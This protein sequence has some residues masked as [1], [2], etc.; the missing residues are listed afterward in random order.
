MRVRKLD[1][2]G[3][4]QFGFGQ[5][6]FWK[7]VPDAPA[8]CVMTRLQLKTGE[9]FLD[10]REGTPWDTEVLGKYTGST[11]DPVIRSRALGTQGVTGILGYVSLLSRDRRAFAVA[12]QVD[13][14]YGQK[15]VAGPI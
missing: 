15:I 13:T 1:G 9:W 10:T 14:R 5:S 7:D 8:Q 12:M 11:R 4:M 6:D 2:D 3:D